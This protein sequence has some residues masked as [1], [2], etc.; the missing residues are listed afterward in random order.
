MWVS[1]SL[2]LRVW[3][4]V[5]SRFTLYWLIKVGEWELKK[6]GR[7]EQAGSEIVCYHVNLS[8]LQKETS[9][10]SWPGSLSSRVAGMWSLEVN[11]FEMDVSI[12]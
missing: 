7:E 11:V 2:G 10:V 9:W 6:I 3:G 8:F 4:L 12:A 1:A 5:F